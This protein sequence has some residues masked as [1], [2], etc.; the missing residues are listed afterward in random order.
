[1]NNMV[2]DKSSLNI[3]GIPQYVR[4]RELL[5]RSLQ[6][7]EFQVGDQIP[8]E[9]EL[10]QTYVVSRMTARRAVNDLAE[11]G[12]LVRQSG[13]GTF[14]CD[15]KYGRKGSRLTSFFEE[16]ER[17]GYHATSRVLS[18]ELK[19][20]TKE[21][22]AKL[23][24]EA[25]DKVIRI[26][27]LRYVDG[28]PVSLQK[29]YIPYQLFPDLLD[30]TGLETQSLYQIYEQRGFEIIKGKDRITAVKPNAEQIRLLEIS[31]AIPVILMERVTYAKGDKLIEFVRS[32]AR[33]DLYAYEVEMLR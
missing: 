24:L 3:S 11:E 4:I 18:Q 30:R 21:V 8:S 12:L 28:K 23:Q 14:V 22:A 31:P 13:L 2:A 9:T 5:R 32:F 20:A 16:M 7:G 25:G 29:A 15:P 1:M 6:A 10:A 26:V 19:E 17:Q 33:A 27:R